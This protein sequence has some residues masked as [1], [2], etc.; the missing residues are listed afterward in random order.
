MTC[1]SKV[2]DYFITPQLHF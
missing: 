1:H 2:V